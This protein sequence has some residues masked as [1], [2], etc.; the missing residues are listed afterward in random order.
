M[1]DVYSGH[2]AI[3]E[4]YRAYIARVH[5]TALRERYACLGVVVQSLETI[6]ITWMHIVMLVTH[7]SADV[8]PELG[9]VR[10]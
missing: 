8:G 10:A 4:T 3:H 6:V 9:P 7:R 1:A 2:S 5:L